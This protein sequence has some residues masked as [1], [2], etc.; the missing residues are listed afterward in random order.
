MSDPEINEELAN[1]PTD[2]Y[3]IRNEEQFAGRKLAEDKSLN[4]KRVYCPTGSPDID[5]VSPL[6]CN[7]ASYSNPLQWEL[8]RLYNGHYKIC[9]RGAPTKEIDNL[10]FALVID[11]AEP[12]EWVI[13]RRH[14]WPEGPRPV[15]T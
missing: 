12:D 10:L 3:Y 15:Y 2:Q 4:P 14:Q 9:A 13:T 8:E 11:R 5:L 7:A 1:L 6:C